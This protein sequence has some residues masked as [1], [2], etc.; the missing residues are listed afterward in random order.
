MKYV[1][2]RHIDAV[3]G[4]FGISDGKYHIG[5]IIQK[6]GQPPTQ[7]LHINIK[8]FVEAQQNGSI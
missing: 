5:H 2:V 1:E 8:P 7:L 6:E 3:K 4:N